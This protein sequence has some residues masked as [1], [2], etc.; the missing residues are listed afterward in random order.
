MKNLILLG[1]VVFAFFV[2]FAGMLSA[3]DAT[4]TLDDNAG[5]SS[6]VVQD[7]DK[8]NQF[9]VNSDGQGY[10]A[11]NVGIGTT[12]PG[13]NLDVLGDIN[14][15]ASDV[16]RINSAGALNGDGYSGMNIGGGIT[17]AVKI[18]A[19]SN[20]PHMT[21]STGGNVG[22][23]TTNPGQKLTVAGTI[24]STSGG[25]KFPDGTTQTTAASGSATIAD[26]SVTQTKLKTATGEVSESA[27]GNPSATLP[28]GTYGF[29]PQIKQTGGSNANVS[30][31]YGSLGGTYVTNIFNAGRATGNADD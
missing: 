17:G 29:Y 16:I 26:A 21:V 24:E 14:I 25:V 23:G 13:H 30:L 6:L 5:S 28:G 7:S 15:R 22:I 18:F 3:G 31:C 2:Y 10:F 20:G 27:N 12:A 11:G 9:K 8:V 19:G 1:S 4:I